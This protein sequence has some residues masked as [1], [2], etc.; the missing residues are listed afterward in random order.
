[1]PGLS[2]AAWPDRLGRAHSS[3]A[4]TWLGRLG[5]WDQGA[6]PGRLGRQR[7]P[8]WPARLGHSFF[9]ASSS[10]RSSRSSDIMWLTNPVLGRR[11]IA[12]PGDVTDEAKVQSMIVKTVA[13]LG[14]LQ[15]VRD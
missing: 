14:D 4:A 5:R 3:P 12:I 7:P 13:D 1:M 6:P 15:V 2:C 10:S 8:I 9:G 11:A